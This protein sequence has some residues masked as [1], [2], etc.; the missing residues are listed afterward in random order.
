MKVKNYLIKNLVE[1]GIEGT[2]THD[3]PAKAAYAVWNFQDQVVKANKAIEEKR[4][5][6]IVSAGIKDGAEIEKR[7]KELK[8][9][10]SRSEEEEKELIEIRGKINKFAELYAQLMNDESELEVKSISFEDY[11]ALSRENRA[12]PVPVPM[13][14]LDKDGNPKMRTVTI[15]FYTVFQN[16]LKDV[17]WAAP[18][19]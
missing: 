13:D 18:E 11:H 4:M 17:L 14:E 3:I 10:D 5:G 16:V 15:D 2:T 8:A 6:L 9:I 1:N 12:I 7:R 19:E